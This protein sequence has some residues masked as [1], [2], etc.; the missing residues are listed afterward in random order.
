MGKGVVRLR[1]VP[2]V[3]TGCLMAHAMVAGDLAKSHAQN[4]GEK[5]QRSD[6]Q[7]VVGPRTCDHPFTSD[8]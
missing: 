8:L 1:H 6:P 3:R 2:V 5:A 7:E 4:A